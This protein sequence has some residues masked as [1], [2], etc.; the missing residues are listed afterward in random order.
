MP[1]KSD[2]IPRFW[3]KIRKSD[4]CWEWTASTY[5]TGYGV[6]CPNQNKVPAHRYM[7]EL[8]NGPI[9]DGLWVL[10]DCDNRLCVR[11]D[12]LHLGTRRDNIDEAVERKRTAWGT[13]S[14]SAKLTET[15]VR[16]IFYS[17]GKVKDIAQRF[18]VVQ[19]TVSVIRRGLSWPNLNL[20]SQ[21]KDMTHAE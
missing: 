9:P 10:H 8:I 2:P 14:A 5:T 19:S 15:Q 11:P 16:E 4:G 18:G 12:H 17:T 21:T 7:W 6:F 3:S 20:K 1:P 13:R